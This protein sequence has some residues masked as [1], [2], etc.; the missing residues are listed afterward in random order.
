MSLVHAPVILLSQVA[1][2]RRT[3]RLAH[4]LERLGVPPAAREFPFHPLQQHRPL[5]SRMR[6]DLAW[7][8][9][10]VALEIDGG[11]WTGGRHVRPAGFL[12]DHHKRNEAARYGWRIV[13]TTW[14]A[15]EKAPGN[16]ASAL[17]DALAWR[18]EQTQ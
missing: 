2:K 6:F 16:L 3:T 10:R 17:L 4:M 8:A 1:S 7:P 18:V 5:Q 15:V 11:V 14:Q 13:Y 12:R 9:E